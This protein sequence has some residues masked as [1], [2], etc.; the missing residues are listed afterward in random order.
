L[1]FSFLSIS[2]QE[3]A[4]SSWVPSG[5]YGNGTG[6]DLYIW[7]E[8]TPCWTYQLNTAVA[9]TWL[10]IISIYLRKGRGYLYSTQALNP[11]KEFVG[12]LNNGNVSF[13][14]TPL[15]LMQLLEALI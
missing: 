9:P 8:P 1:A 6:Y 2:N 14:I 12:L 15:A 5:T 13:P 11:T 7:N 3:I 10:S 4:G